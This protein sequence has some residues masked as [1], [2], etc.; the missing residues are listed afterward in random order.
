[1]RTQRNQYP[2]ISLPS[3]IDGVVLATPRRKRQSWGSGKVVDRNVVDSE[4]A[5]ADEMRH[6]KDGRSVLDTVSAPG[7]SGSAHGNCKPS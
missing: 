6:G 1:M 3:N 7:M 4:V 2:K 5:D